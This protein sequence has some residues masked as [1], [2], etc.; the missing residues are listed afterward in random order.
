MIFE[1]ALAT[2]SAISS[3]KR[4]IEAIYIAK[5]KKSRD[6]DYI[7]KIAAK[8]Q[9]KVIREDR[10]KIDELAS[11]KTHGG[12]IAFVSAREYQ[13]ID[14]TKDTYFMI[15]G[16]EDP[17]NLGYI[18]RTLKAFGY[19]H[20]LMNKRDLSN[21]EET[22]IKSSAGAFDMLDITM[23]DDIIK[24]LDLLA[25]D[26]HLIAMSRTDKAKDLFRYDAPKK[27]V[28]ILG[29]EKRGINKDVLHMCDDEVFIPYHSDFRPA[30]NA[31]S[32]LAVICTGLRMR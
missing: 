25:K 8:A 7:L 5:D 6:V 24:D 12:I 15:D 31:S 2:K 21:M 22:I 16:I 4:H 32:A 26:H 28:I 18:F 19:D 23:S 27:K 11:G 20:V 29:G 30:L 1:G 9:I 14:L 3:K 17:F 13:K 10:E